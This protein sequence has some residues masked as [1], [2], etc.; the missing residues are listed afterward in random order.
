MGK[1]ENKIAVGYLRVSSKGQIRGHGF[2]RQRDEIRRY[3]KKHGYKI[4]EWYKEAYTGTEQDRPEFLRM[5]EE[6]L[7]NGCR[8]IIIE[9]MDRFGRRS[10]VSEQL[11]ALLIRKDITMIS[12]MTEQNIT[13]D[14]QDENDPWKKFIVQIQNNFA[15]LDKRLLVNKLR[16]ARE[17]KR[18]NTG[19]CEGRKPYGYYPGEDK[20]IKRIRELYRKPKGEK[21]PGFMT[22]A[23]KLNEEGIPTRT[24]AKWSDV[25]VKSILTRKK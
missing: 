1:Q 23:K 7:C 13:K 8:T 24:G 14:M 16:K 3:A 17:A 5:I 22:I 19:R 18:T 6:L 25:L 12:A 21:R 20:I 15:E 4:I 2:E 9:C 11:L 10:M